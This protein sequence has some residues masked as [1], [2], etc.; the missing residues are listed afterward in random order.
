MNRMVALTFLILVMSGCTGQ[1]NITTS[2]QL[3]VEDIRESLIDET[4]GETSILS[5]RYKINYSMDGL[6]KLNL[7]V[8]NISS[9]DL[10]DFSFIALFPRL[11]GEEDLHAIIE[12]VNE[13]TTIKMGET[14][15]V[16]RDFE[17]KKNMTDKQMKE[18]F[19]PM[20]LRYYW[21][22]NE[23]INR[24]DVAIGEPNS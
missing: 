5:L 4:D 17:F 16:E 24:F 15:V 22:E 1:E 21:G 12:S 14:L 19:S 7:A 11:V 6:V 13:P 20:K 23:K 18:L 9:S 2:L 8:K 10:N 3:E